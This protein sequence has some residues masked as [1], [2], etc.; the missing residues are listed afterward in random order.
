M[1]DSLFLLSLKYLGGG[2]RK[3]DMYYVT[4]IRRT[5]LSQLST[6]SCHRIGTVEISRR[7]N[8]FV[9]WANSLINMREKNT[10]A[11]MINCKPYITRK[12][13]QRV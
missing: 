11:N 12:C 6:W 1:V 2:G 4:L 8:I 7:N 3:R 10:V 13:F 5:P 9:Q